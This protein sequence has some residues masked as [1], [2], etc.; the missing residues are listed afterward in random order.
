MQASKFIEKSTIGMRQISLVIKIFKFA[1]F[2]ILFRIMFKFFEKMIYNSQW[3]TDS[4]YGCLPRAY[5][6][7]TCSSMSSFR[8]SYFLDDIAHLEFN[9]PLSWDHNLS[10]FLLQQ[11]IGKMRRILTSGFYILKR[12]PLMNTS[13]N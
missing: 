10:M 2:K 4:T 13:L 9:A 6:P 7:I 5:C 12:S 8:M 1:N 11:S 3:P